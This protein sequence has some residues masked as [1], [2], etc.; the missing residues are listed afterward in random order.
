MNQ[1]VSFLQFTKTDTNE[2]HRDGFKSESIS[3]ELDS[4]WSAMDLEKNL[5]QCRY[6]LPLSAERAGVES[7]PYAVYFVK[8]DDNVSANECEREIRNIVN[9]SQVSNT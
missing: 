2:S 1:T 9:A 5:L 4:G 3:I 7:N 6:S 8:Q